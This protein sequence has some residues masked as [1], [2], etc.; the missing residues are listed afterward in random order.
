[1]KLIKLLEA[2]YHSQPAQLKIIAEW[3]EMGLTNSGW[4][5]SPHENLYYIKQ[6]EGEAASDKAVE[7]CNACIDFINQVTGQNLRHIDE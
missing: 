5:D 2:T 1:M 3:L 6:E 4:M 7:E